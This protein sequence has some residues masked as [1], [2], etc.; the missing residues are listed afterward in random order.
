MV[1]QFDEKG[2]I[3]TDIVSKQPV[4]VLIQLLTSQIRGEIHV[5]RDARI[6]DELDSTVK[7]LAVTNAT[8]LSV[9]GSAILTKCR[10]LSVNIN[11]IISV[12]PE[13]EI[14]QDEF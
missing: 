11:Q 1:T 14:L 10:F 3:F 12:I 4:K 2:K 13:E 6:K 5:K 9:D 7:F 8:I